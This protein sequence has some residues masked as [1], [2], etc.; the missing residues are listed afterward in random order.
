MTTV[1]D[2]IRRSGSARNDLW[3]AEQVASRVRE[4]ADTLRRLPAG[5]WSNVGWGMPI[6][7]LEWIERYSKR[8][9]GPGRPEPTAIDRMGEVFDDWMQYLDLEE[10]RVCWE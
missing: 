2:H 5:G 6:H 1:S 7:E 4:A 9:T 10:Q 3:T 8:Q